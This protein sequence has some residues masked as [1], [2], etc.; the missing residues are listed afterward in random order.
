MQFLDLYSVVMYSFFP[1]EMRSK[2]KVAFSS[3]A[4][5]HDN[6]LI[7]VSSR[8]VVIHGLQGIH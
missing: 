6:V 1:T 5:Q 2:L 4:M 3:A 7:I 8:S